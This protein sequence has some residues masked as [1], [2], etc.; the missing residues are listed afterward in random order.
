MKYFL[1]FFM[2]W[3]LLTELAF[4]G[5]PNVFYYVSDGTNELY[6]INRVTGTRVLI[7]AT[8]GA[9]SIEAIAFYP[10]PGANQ[11]F[12]ANGGD[13]GTLALTGGSAGAFTSIGQID[14]G[15][16]ANGSSGPQS[17]DDVDGLM[18][19]GQTFKMWAIERKSGVTPDLLFQI[20][21]TTGLF[22][23][24]AF[25]SGIDYLVILGSGID[26]DVDDL[27]VNPLTGK[28]YATSNDNGA[29]D[30]LLEINK[31]TG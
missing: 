22:V 24:N 13:F 29:S 17:L 21:I 11:L 14:G 23:A 28:L 30:I 25:G 5:D 18:L 27:A 7:G 3:A 10:I 1:T 6:S 9:T 4:A 12:A 31:F 20:D 26:V 2:F 19:D 8:T 15:G 16:T